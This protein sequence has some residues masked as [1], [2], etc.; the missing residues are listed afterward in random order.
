MGTHTAEAQTFAEH[1][2]EEAAQGLASEGSQLAPSFC[3][4][5]GE[6]EGAAFEVEQPA[7]ASAASAASTTETE[8]RKRKLMSG[9]TLIPLWPDGDLVDAGELRG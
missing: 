9:G 3:S 6:D 4:G 7:S 1:D 5:P 8:E 2:E